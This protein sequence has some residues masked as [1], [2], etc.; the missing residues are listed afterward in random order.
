MLM[1]NALTTARHG[2]RRVAGLLLA[3]REQWSGEV[4]AGGVRNRW[5]VWELVKDGQ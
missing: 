1:G 5:G 4:I 3:L 2:R